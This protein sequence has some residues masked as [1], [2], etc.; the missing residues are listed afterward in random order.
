MTELAVVYFT[1]PDPSVADRLARGLVESGLV[2]CVNQMPAG[3]SVYR[4]N[5]EVQHAA[6]LF[7]LAKTTN[8][9]VPAVIDWIEREHPYELPCVTS[10]RVERSS[11]P[12]A[13]WVTEQVTAPPDE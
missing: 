13:D 6:E 3:R 4:W 11:D 10:W 1:A 9:R 5:G 2:A 7:L 8:A 12:F